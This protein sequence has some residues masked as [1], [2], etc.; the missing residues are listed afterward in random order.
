M[1][2]QN[3]TW[4]SGFEFR[5]RAGVYSRMA[6]IERN[7]RPRESN[8]LKAYAVFDRQSTDISGQWMAQDGAPRMEM[9]NKNTAAN[10]VLHERKNGSESV[11]GWIG[12]NLEQMKIWPF[13]RRQNVA[14]STT[15]YIDGHRAAKAAAGAA[16]AGAA[17]WA[18]AAGGGG[19]R[20]KGRGSNGNI[21]N[22]KM[23]ATT[24][25][26]KTTTWAASALPTTTT[27]ATYQQRH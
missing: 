12:L 24:L 18:A 16:T 14:A 19:G 13:G 26:K 7:R 9:E 8:C 23:A 27:V 17:A 2:H 5:P 10:G 22:N 25:T 20:G 3:I 4:S 15:Y 6:G 1:S 21:N 11:W